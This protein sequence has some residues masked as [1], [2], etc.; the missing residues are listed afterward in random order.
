MDIEKFIQNIKFFCSMRNVK[1][2]VACREA[3]VGGS[4]I[5]NMESRGSIPSVEKAQ[6]L[7]QYLGVTTSTLLGE[8]QP[9]GVSELGTVTLRDPFAARFSP[10]DYFHVSKAEYELICAYKNAPSTVQRA[11]ADMLDRYK[12]ATNTNAV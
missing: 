11:V 1:P 4:F 10:P 12:G 8:D 9:R 5:N 6:M 3:G 7:A 2:T